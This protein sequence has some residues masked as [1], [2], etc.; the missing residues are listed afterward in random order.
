MSLRV[1]TPVARTQGFFTAKLM[2]FIMETFD[3]NS[4]KSPLILSL[5]AACIPL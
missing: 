2:A 1:S 4:V 3:G 5:V